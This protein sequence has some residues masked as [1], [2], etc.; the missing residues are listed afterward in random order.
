MSDKN[1]QQSDKGND[2]QSRKKKGLIDYSLKAFENQVAFKINRQDPAIAAFLYANGP[3]Q[4]TNGVLISLGTEHPE[5]KWSTNTIYLDGSGGKELK[6]VD[7]TDFPGETPNWKN[8]HNN[9]YM[10]NAMVMFEAAVAEFDEVVQNY[11]FGKEDST[12]SSAK[13]GHKVITV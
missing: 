13:D 1:E 10:R 8:P 2:G 7:K 12:K 11:Y 4:A 6:H 3:Y 5:W 9:Q